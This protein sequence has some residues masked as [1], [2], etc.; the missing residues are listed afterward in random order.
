[1]TAAG[2]QT[3]TDPLKAVAAAMANAAGSVRN[4]AEDAFAKARH[5]APATGQVLSRFAYSTSYYAS[6]GVVF[7]TLLVAKVIPGGETIAAGLIEGASAA[8]DAVG[9]M[10]N[11]G[12]P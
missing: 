8:K 5:A 6:F 9:A 3:A 1:M 10:K 2:V 4:G 12:T 11:R 7:P